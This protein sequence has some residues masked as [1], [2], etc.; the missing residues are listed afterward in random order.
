MGVYYNKDIFDRLG[1]SVPATYAEF[2]TICKTLQANGIVPLVFSFQTAGRV[3]HL[4]QAMNVAWTLDGV[5]RFVKVMNGSGTVSGE[6]VFRLLAER[7]GEV[8]SYGNA[9]AFALPD[10]G[11]WEVFANGGAAMCITG[12]YA[13]GTIL[14]ANSNL[15]MG[16]FPIPNDSPETTTLLTG[17][18][19]ALCVSAS[20]GPQEREAALAFL[21]FLSR[22][23]NAQTF[24]D[25]DGAPSTINGVVYQDEGLLP[26]TEK[27][28]SG[29]LWDWMGSFIP[30]TIVNEMYSVTQQYLLDKN[31]NAYLSQLEEVIRAGAEQAGL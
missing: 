18:D 9:D 16:V 13:R 15:S 2:I 30:T 10:T 7:M 22:P 21:E 29:P 1:L 31:V 17:I 8:V 23:E 6:P 24:C 3:G 12:S 4:F 28:R 20:A 14:L 5:D 25:H 26:I 19:A 27:M 11:M